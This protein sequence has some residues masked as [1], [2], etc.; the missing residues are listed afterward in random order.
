MVRGR[1]VTMAGKW[2]DEAGGVK[3]F[4]DSEA[5]FKFFHMQTFR[6]TAHHRTC[7]LVLKAKHGSRL[8]DFWD[9]VWS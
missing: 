9:F 7:T 4:P 5:Y 2:A 6:L 8:D 1:T 3:F